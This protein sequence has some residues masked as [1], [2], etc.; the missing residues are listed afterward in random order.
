L[1]GSS[2]RTIVTDYYGNLDGAPLNPAF[3]NAAKKEIPVP[4]EAMIK[5]LADLGILVPGMRI[6]NEETGT[7][8]T[9]TE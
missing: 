6:R 5:T 2:Y 9:L 8:I 1:L 7:L 3:F 4:N